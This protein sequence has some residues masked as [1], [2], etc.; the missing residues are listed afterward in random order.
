VGGEDGSR[1]GENRE[2]AVGGVRG[3]GMEASSMGVTRRRGRPILGGGSEGHGRG[4]RVE[5]C[6]GGWVDFAGWEVL[7]SLSP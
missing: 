1:V 4:R 2:G 7:V 6:G 3:R 5:S